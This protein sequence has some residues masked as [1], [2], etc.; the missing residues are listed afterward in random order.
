MNFNH[1]LP[2]KRIRATCKGRDGDCYLVPTGNV[3]SMIGGHVNV[4]VYCRNCTRREDLFL[5]QKQYE[6][7][8]NLINK[9]VKRE[10][11]RVSTS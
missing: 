8:K 7:Q 1:L 2:E 11:K 10:E 5:T 4:T 6:V 9:E 3:R